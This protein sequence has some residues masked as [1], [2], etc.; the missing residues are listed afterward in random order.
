MQ[1]ATHSLQ[2]RHTCKKASHHTCWQ[3]GEV[4]VV[5]YRGN[6]QVYSAWRWRQ[7][8]ILRVHTYNQVDTALI[9]D[10]GLVIDKDCRSLGCSSDGL[11][12]IP[13]NKG[14]IVEIKCPYT[15]AERSR[16]VFCCG[17]SEDVLL[18]SWCRRKSGAQTKTQIP[19]SGAR[20]DGHNEMVLVRFHCLVTDWDVCWANKRRKRSLGRKKAKNP[21]FPPKRFSSRGCALWLQCG[22]PIRELTSIDDV[23]I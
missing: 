14:G 4:L 17:D 16:F 18:Q 2:L 20:N 3:F 13:G 1:V 10:S 19:L 23:I 9:K 15:T 5:L 6:T 7:E 11:V 22:Q 8:V 12:D 21:Q